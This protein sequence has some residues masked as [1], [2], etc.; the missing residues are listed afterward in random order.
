MARADLLT[1]LVKF[2]TTDDKARFRK[3]AEAII[4]EER[5]KKHTVLADKLEEALRHSKLPPKPIADNNGNGALSLSTQYCH[6]NNPISL[7]YK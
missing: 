4:A 6:T 7:F 5:A 3:V 1:D 2:G